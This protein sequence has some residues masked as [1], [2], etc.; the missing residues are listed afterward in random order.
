MHSFTKGQREVVSDLLRKVLVSDMGNF[1]PERFK[2]WVKNMDSQF[3]KM[4]MT[5]QFELDGPM[6]QLHCMAG[7]FPSEYACAYWAR[8]LKQ[9]NYSTRAREN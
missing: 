5:L 9:L 6:I 7:L 1:T 3:R 2:D 8:N 4:G